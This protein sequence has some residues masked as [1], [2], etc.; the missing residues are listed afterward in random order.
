MEKVIALKVEFLQQTRKKTVASPNLKKDSL[1]LRKY[2]IFLKIIEKINKKDK[3][4][5]I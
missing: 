5:I 2:K 1:G 3:D 4:D